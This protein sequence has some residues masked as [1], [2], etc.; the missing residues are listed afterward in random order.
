VNATIAQV[1]ALHRAML[2]DPGDALA[3]LAYADA[4][5]EAGDWRQAR[6]V[7]GGSQ[8]P[9]I[10]HAPGCL[11]PWRCGHTELNPGREPG[12]PAWHWKGVLVAVAVPFEDFMRDCRD[13]FTA[14]PVTQVWLTDRTPHAAAPTLHGWH[15]WGAE[16]VCAGQLFRGLPRGERWPALSLSKWY[17]TEDRA[18]RALSASCVKWGRRKAGLPALPP[19]RRDG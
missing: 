2:L 7:R 1:G 15:L 13:I 12:G 17:R 3:R 10:I 9:P 4:L 6:W 14:Q 5:D 18:R 11:T 19:E 16:P 8:L